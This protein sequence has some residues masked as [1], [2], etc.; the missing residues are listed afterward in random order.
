MSIPV[1][2]KLRDVQLVN[3]P[4][5]DLVAMQKEHDENCADPDHEC[6]FCP[7][8]V[9]IAFPPSDGD[10]RDNIERFA[11]LTYHAD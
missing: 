1:F 7:I 4:T 3:T 9:V 10:D 5:S 2:K 8:E 11:V 6:D